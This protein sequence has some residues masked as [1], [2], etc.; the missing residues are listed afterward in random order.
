MGLFDNIKEGIDDTVDKGKE[1]VDEVKDE[2]EERTGVDIDRD[3]N[4]GGSPEP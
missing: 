1:V 2:A 3:G 4:L